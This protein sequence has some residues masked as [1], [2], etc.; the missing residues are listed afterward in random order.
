M[1]SDINEFKV[2]DNELPIIKFIKSY[3]TSQPFFKRVSEALPADSAAAIRQNNVSI[4]T[5]SEEIDK[6]GPEPKFVTGGQYTEGRINVLRKFFFELMDAYVH[7][8]NITGATTIEDK[9]NNVYSDFEKSF[10]IQISK[11][12]RDFTTI[13]TKLFSILEITK[14]SITDYCI[15]SPPKTVPSVYSESKEKMQYILKGGGNED[16]EEDYEE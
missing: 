13:S 8:Y 5:V 3:N 9:V 16:N 10:N 2:N 1:R 11:K 15:Q 4:R 6:Q 12:G 14:K 7:Q